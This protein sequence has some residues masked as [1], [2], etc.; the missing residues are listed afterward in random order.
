MNP[1]DRW[2]QLPKQRLQHALTLADRIH[3]I[4]GVHRQRQHWTR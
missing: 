1:T 2:K 3:G 4:H